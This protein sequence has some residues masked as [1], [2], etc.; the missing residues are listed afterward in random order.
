M[1]SQNSSGRWR[2]CPG[3]GRERRLAAGRIV[4]CDHNRW[5]SIAWA[6]APCEGSGQA[7]R[8]A[9]R[10]SAGGARVMAAEEEPGHWGGRAA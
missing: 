9:G 1:C 4:M 8:P 6:M 3:C 10:P 5:D 2:L 7:P